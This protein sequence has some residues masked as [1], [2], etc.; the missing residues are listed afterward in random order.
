ML[1]LKFLKIP[2]TGCLEPQLQIGKMSYYSLLRVGFN[3]S[4]CQLKL[5]TELLLQ[6]P[7]CYIVCY[8][9]PKLK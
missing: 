5:T 1:C 7:P 4:S 3:Y 8:F 6:I 9:L 2:L